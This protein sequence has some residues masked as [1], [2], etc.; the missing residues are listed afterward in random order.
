MESIP[1]G[2]IVKAE[3]FVDTG[4]ANVMR[5]TYGRLGMLPAVFKVEKVYSAADSI[6]A[7]REIERSVEI[8]EIHVD[9]FSKVPLR[10]ANTTAKVDESGNPILDQH[11]K[12]VLMKV[13]SELTREQEIKLAPLYEQFKKQKDSTETNI[14]TW[15]AINDHERYLLTQVGIWS[16]EQ[17]NAMP[18]YERYRLGPAGE[19]LWER[20]ERHRVAKEGN[21][22][23]EA[24]EEMLRVLEENKRE[25]EAR[26]N[27]EEQMYRM[28]EQLAELTAGKKKPSGRIKVD[29][30]K[31]EAA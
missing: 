29:V 10:V 14:A 17:L 27:L 26:R 4:T 25:R 9:K 21:K 2:L 6:E 8:C 1:E 7:G 11:G 30:P 23:K 13:R 28:Q 24:T 15:Q 3:G 22:Q 5:P 31:R 16:V 18:Q 20:S 19:E 12:P